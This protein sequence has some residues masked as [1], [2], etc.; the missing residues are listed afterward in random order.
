MFRDERQKRVRSLIGGMGKL[1]WSASFSK[2]RFK[3][4]LT[5][6]CFD[7]TGI[8]KGLA[9]DDATLQLLFLLFEGTKRGRSVPG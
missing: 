1:A 3:V 9:P 4:V 6:G 7:P 8:T 5:Y 2:C